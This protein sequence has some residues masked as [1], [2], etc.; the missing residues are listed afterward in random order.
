MTANDAGRPWVGHPLFAP[1]FLAVFLAVDW[2]T[3]IHQPPAVNLT[4]WNPPAGLYV[5]LLLTAPRRRAVALTFA[6]LMLG[7]L[8]VRAAPAPLHLLLLTN[9]AITAAYATGAWV[10]REKLRLDPTLEHPRQMVAFMIAVPLGAIPAALGFALPYAVAGVFAWDTLAQVAVQYWVGDV[11]GILA[12]TPAALIAL[13]GTVSAGPRVSAAE[14][15]MQALAVVAA[16]LITFGPLAPEPSKLFYI[17]FLPIIWVAMRRGLPGAAVAILAVQAGIVL[18]LQMIDG[19]HDVIYD[20]LLMVALTAT[21]LLAGAIVGERWRLDAALRQRQAELA[22]VA[23]LSL[24][25]EMASSL[26]HELNQPLFTTINYTKASRAFLMRD[27]AGE[28]TIDMMNRAVAEAE[29]AADV[30]R[31]IR[32]FLRQDAGTERV[33]LGASVAEVLAL[34]SPDLERHGIAVTTHIPADLPSLWADKVQLDQVLLNLVRNS[35][36]ALIPAAG[37]SKEIH[38]CARHGNGMV[39]VEVA[40]NGPGVPDDKIAPLFDLFFT[41]KPSGMGLGLP[42]CRSLVEAHGGRLW[43]ERNGPDGACFSFTLPA[44]TP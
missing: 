2:A 29:R 43:L 26:A 7:D 20:Q 13:H 9:L 28:N 23:R 22:R 3:F 24:L 19:Q 37:R 34:S 11:I 15:L 17:L 41:T 1:G 4:P 16:L 32:G 42:I 35:I 40:D 44:A 6:A 30:L 12:V 14:T 38:I 36:D 5:A 18:A 31:R 25:G 39:T 27:G 8:V 33:E 21:G 10:L